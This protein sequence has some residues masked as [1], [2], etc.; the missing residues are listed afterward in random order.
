MTGL[1]QKNGAVF[2][3][4]RIASETAAL[5]AQKLGVGDADLA[6]AF[7]AVAALANEPVMTFEPA[8]TRTVVNARITRLRGLSEDCVS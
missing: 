7:D 8:R 5:G 6:L 4:V 3:H 1:S 2:S